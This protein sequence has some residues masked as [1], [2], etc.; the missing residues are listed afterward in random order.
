[1]D[2][3]NKDHLLKGGMFAR[4]EVLVDRHVNAVQIP[5]DAVSRLEEFQYVYIVKDGKA[6]QVSV[7]LGSR[8]G[9]RVEVTKG[10]AGD[11]QVIV[12]GKDLVSDGMA[13]QA[14][15]L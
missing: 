7:E 6:H 15:P 11:E 5:L 2:L 10:L 8:I 14:Q 9:N 1:V 13:V 3:P 4:V 12:S